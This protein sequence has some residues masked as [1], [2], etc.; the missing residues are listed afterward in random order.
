M[1]DRFRAIVDS[2]PHA[3]LLVD[4]Q[5]IITLANRRAELL[6]GYGP[7]E[8]LGRPLADLVPPDLRERHDDHVRG[9]F[10]EP[11]TREMG[12]GRELR[13]LRK[14][15][16]LVPLEIGLGPVQVSS[17]AATIASII[18]ISERR[19]FEADVRRL[20][21]EMAQFVYSVSH[22]LKAPLVTIRGFLGALE[23]DLEMGDADAIRDSMARIHKA[24][25]RVT[26]LVEDLLRL[27]R[28][29]RTDVEHAPVTVSAL[30]AAA[31]S[32]LEHELGARGVHPTIT[33]EDV[34]LLVDGARFTSVFQNL[35][36][37]ALHHG[38]DP[39]APAITVRVEST[40]SGVAID[41]HDNGPGIA[42]AYHQRV[43]QPFERL[44]RE[45]GGSG[46]G[47]SIAQRVVRSHGGRIVL[48]SGRGQGTTFRVQLPREC[49]VSEEDSA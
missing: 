11:S 18:D 42:P 8:L 26:D 2:A 41:V 14:D 39:A 29:G 32:G 1:P 36:G 48:D 22:D 21:E 24:S 38:C 35:I 44:G 10:S 20:N 19:R 17:G 37:N 16:S 4:A 7:G 33:G 31:T 47:L 15:G 28:A 45:D 43:F 9:F 23:E 27:S 49:V 3:I 13:G 40:H 5:R 6:F 34:T 46:I 30:L 25:S 12:A